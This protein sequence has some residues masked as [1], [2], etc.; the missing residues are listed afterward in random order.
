MIG[1]LIFVVSVFAGYNLV[2]SFIP[3]RRKKNE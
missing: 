2:F 1:F 3:A